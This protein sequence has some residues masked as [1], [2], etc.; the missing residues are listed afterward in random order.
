MKIIY[1]ILFFIVLFSACGPKMADLHDFYP[2]TILEYEGLYLAPI[3]M[4]KEQI[5]NIDI[6]NK[7][8][9]SNNPFIHKEDSVYLQGK[10]AWRTETTVYEE[11]KFYI[12]LEKI[13]H[14]NGKQKVKFTMLDSLKNKVSNNLLQVRFQFTETNYGYEGPMT[15]SIGQPTDIDQEIST[16]I[17]THINCNLTQG[18]GRLVQQNA[19]GHIQFMDCYQADKFQHT[20]DVD[21]SDGEIVYTELN[22]ELV[23]LQFRR[24]IFAEQRKA[25][26]TAHENLSVSY[27]IS[28]QA[29]QKITHKRLQALENTL[30]MEG[31]WEGKKPTLS[32]DDLLNLKKKFSSVENTLINDTLKP[33]IIQYTIGLNQ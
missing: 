32:E 1:I 9:D 5:L 11:F 13:A 23:G 19:N 28:P 21:Y 26:M 3:N 4:E 27:S 15:V 14:L 25:L 18:D 30:L 31:L 22:P 2:E 20:I 17:I 7:S 24:N 29:D 33:N 12:L 16:D 6:C 10:W 8:A